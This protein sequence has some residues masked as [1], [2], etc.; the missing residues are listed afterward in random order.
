[1]DIAQSLLIFFILVISAKNVG[2][3]KGAKARGNK[4]KVFEH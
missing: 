3:E 4:R 1:M 2:D